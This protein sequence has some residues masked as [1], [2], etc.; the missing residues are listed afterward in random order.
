[1]CFAIGRG[2]KRGTVL[3][4]RELPPPDPRRARAP[5]RQSPGHRR[6]GRRHWR[7]S[8]SSWLE[9]RW[10]L[11]RAAAVP[12]NRRS[13]RDYRKLA[14]RAHAA[15]AK[16]VVAADLLALTLLEPPGELGADVVPWARRSASACPWASA[17]PTPASC[18]REETAR[19]KLP[20]R[21]WSESPIDAHGEPALPAGDP[22]PRAAH[23]ARQGDQ[24]HLHRAGAARDHGGH[25]RGLPRT[26]RLRRSRGACTR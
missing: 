10:S 26:R 15:G 6:C 23:P 17:A 24:Q 19:A 5:A 9:R 1:M 20:G 16:L 3:R 8:I 11:R 14:E 2:K 21:H 25:V 13:H 22:D 7:R 4:G 12:H 18:P